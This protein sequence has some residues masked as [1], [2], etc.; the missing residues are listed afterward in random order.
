MDGWNF[1]IIRR[2][3]THTLVSACISV[4]PIDRTLWSPEKAG[5]KKTCFSWSYLCLSVPHILKNSVVFL[6]F[7]IKPSK[8]LL[9]SNS[10]YVFLTNFLLLM[11]ASFQEISVI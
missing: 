1:E 11:I 6:L 2:R 3:M 7:C 5:M 9:F 10:R 8:K 4:C